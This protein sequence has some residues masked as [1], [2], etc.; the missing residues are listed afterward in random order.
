MGEGSHA[1]GTRRPAAIAPNRLIYGINPVREA[2]GGNRRLH[3]VWYHESVAGRDLSAQFQAWACAAGQPVGRLLPA[4]VEELV[5]LSGALDHQGLV[6]EADA[7]AYADPEH[8]LQSNSLLLALD[9]IQDPQNLGA[10]IRSAEIAGAAVVI[11]RHRAAEVTGAVV[12]AA[13]GATEHAA[14]ARVR[15]L[16]DFIAE[17]QGAGFW[18]YGAAARGGL[19]DEQDYRARTVF[20]LGSE[21][22]GL[23]SRVEA[24]CDVLVG[25]PQS[26]K[27]GSLNVSVAAAVLLFEA[28]R[29]RRSP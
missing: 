28:V 12:K 1:S 24:A 3:R 2:L 14:V 27:V 5:A 23:G 18:V 19:Y 7:Y 25:I 10:I 22:E 8:V 15:N 16:A 26:G 9:R 4:P 6:A 17:A 13:A 20:V 29:Q 21:G 11:P